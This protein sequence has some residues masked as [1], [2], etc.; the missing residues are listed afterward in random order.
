MDY[1]LM[2]TFC[3]VQLCIAIY[4]ANFSH[5][6]GQDSLATVSCNITD[7]DMIQICAAWGRLI[8]SLGYEKC[9]L[10]NHN[11]LFKLGKRV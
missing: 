5:H 9:S 3:L 2:K 1:N 8:L 6:R 11:R 10:A 7:L 4:L